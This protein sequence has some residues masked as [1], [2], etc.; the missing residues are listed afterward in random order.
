M[1]EN[2]L[3]EIYDQLYVESVHR[4][5]QKGDKIPTETEIFEVLLK[6]IRQAILEG[7]E[8]VEALHEL[9]E[10]QSFHIREEMEQRRKHEV[11]EAL[12]HGYVIDLDSIK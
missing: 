6:A 12:R 1:K 3:Q 2:T 7:E 4:A 11:D 5:R 10:V 8:T 9:E